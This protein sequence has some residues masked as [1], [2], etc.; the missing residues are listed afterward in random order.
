MAAGQDDLPIGFV[1]L[2]RMGGNMARR[3][4]AKGIPVAGFS[5]DAEQ[6]RALQRE[7]GLVARASLE[8]LVAGLTPPRIVWLMVPAGAATRRT[9]A[10]LGELLDPDDILVDG[11]NS[12]Y[13]ESIAHGEMLAARGVAFLDAGV[14]GGVWGLENG[15][16]LMLGGKESAVARLR[17]FLDS[18][19]V[20][21]GKGWLHCGPQGAG[22]YAKMIHNA[23][24]YG[25]M[26]ALAEGL[27]L[28]R[29]KRD[30]ALDIGAL[31]ELW[32]HGSVIRS[33]LLDLTAGV[34]ASGARLEDVVPRVPDSGEGRWA[35][36]EA[37]ELG[38]PAPA[39]SVA[40]AMRFASQ[41]ANDD[42]ARLLALMRE[43]FG[44]H[45]VTRREGEGGDG[46]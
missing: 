27:A 9:I 18:L 44:G 11:G 21:G 28:M 12:H 33:W 34:L 24:E 26:Q 42:T 38:V 40:L 2:G 8:D 7:A 32:R 1:G 10:A 36:Q 25:M 16:C 3:L 39:A 23:I 31:A 20:E 43:A 14:S 19:A 35:V 6:G 4:M 37:V 15:Y 45:G 22:H 17:P 29:A 5:V 41:G 46:P 30:L 13:R